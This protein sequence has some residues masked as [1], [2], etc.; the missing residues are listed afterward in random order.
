MNKIN[1]KLEWLNIHC[2]NRFFITTTEDQ[3]EYNLRDKHK[4]FDCVNLSKYMLNEELDYLEHM[5]A[6]G[7]L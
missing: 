7:R 5:L 6:C 2:D 1:K 4:V 3:K